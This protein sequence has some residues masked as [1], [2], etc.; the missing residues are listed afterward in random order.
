MMSADFTAM[1]TVTI[2]PIQVTAMVVA[3]LNDNVRLSVFAEW[4]IH[5]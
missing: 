2:I 3:H 4:R 5:P 1:K